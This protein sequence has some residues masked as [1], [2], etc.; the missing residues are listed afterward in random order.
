MKILN[1]GNFWREWRDLDF[2]LILLPML[3][4]GI[5]GMTIFSA[6]LNAGW[7][8]WWQHWLVGGI[9]LILVLAIARIPYEQFLDYHWVIYILTNFSLLLV[10]LIGRS[11]LGAQR[12]IPFLGVNVQPS[13]FAKLG[14][15]IT[16]AAILHNRPI[17][18]PLDIA[19]TLSVTILPFG[20]IFRQPD[21]GTALVFAAIALGMLYWGGA[22]F[23][24]LLLLCSPLISV[25][26]SSVYIPAWLA[27]VALMGV[28]AW[29]TLPWLI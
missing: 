26:L 8:N 20:L 22:K 13:E 3:L 11:E 5:G 19:K 27:W 4:T 12:W 2:I 23:G 21:L 7:T 10:L 14:L 1:S 15:I 24:W 29:Q 9:G 6:E 28:T 25:I 18:H 17:Q 16:L